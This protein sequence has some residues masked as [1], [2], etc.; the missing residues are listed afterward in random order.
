M[1]KKGVNMDPF[2]QL[3]L[4]DTMQRLG[5]SYHFEEEIKEILSKIYNN[6][7]KKQ[8]S[9]YAAALQFRLLRQHGYNIPAGTNGS[10]NIHLAFGGTFCST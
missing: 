2:R 4:V 9:L 3:E 10:I 7:R 8:E 6:Y 5:V 1:L